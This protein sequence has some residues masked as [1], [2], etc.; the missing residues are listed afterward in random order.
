MGITNNEKMNIYWL[1][2]TN[3][4]NNSHHI[5]NLIEKTN[6]NNQNW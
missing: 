5:I 4:Y 3:I 1:Y 2:I 6:L